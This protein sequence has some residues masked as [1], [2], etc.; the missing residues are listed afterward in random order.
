MGSKRK[1]KAKKHTKR[2]LEYWEEEIISTR[3]KRRALSEISNLP[4]NVK[5]EVQ[6]A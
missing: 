6:V 2:K 5:D 3:R 1:G 4:T